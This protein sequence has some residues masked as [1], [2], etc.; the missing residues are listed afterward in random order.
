MRIDPRGLRLFL[1]VCREGTISGGARA[2]HLSQPSVSVAI[3]QLE[4]ALE[5]KLFDRFRQGIQLTPAGEALFKRAEAIENLM[6]TAHREVKL[7]G[8]NITGPL[9]LGGTPGALATLVPQ[10]INNFT[11][12]FPRF[13]LRILERPEPELHRLLRSYEIDIAVLT[14]GM[15]ESPRDMKELAV[16]SDT[17]AIIAGRSNDH[18]PNEISLVD[19][20]D[21]KW[22]LPDAVGG[23]RRQVD[24]LFVSAKAPMPQDVIRC[25]SLLTTKSI[26]RHTEYITVLPK[27]V[28]MPELESGSLRAIRIREATFQRKVGLIW[29][30][31]RNFSH[32]AQAFIEHAKTVS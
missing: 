12:S 22:V 8:E 32:L 10:V 11:K 4:S 28:A 16:M 29:L 9:V 14:A 6:D 20:E 18:L 1:A 23:F 15:K 19:L 13:E 27:Q 17:F 5:A 2:E 30:K 24:A 21:A 3:S 25:D 7:L 26:V 31:E